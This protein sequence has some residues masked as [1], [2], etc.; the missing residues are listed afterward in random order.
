MRPRLLERPQRLVAVLV[1][2]TAVLLGLPVLSSGELRTVTGEGEYR[3]GARDTREDAVRLATEEAKRHALEQVATYIESVSVSTA[4]D[5]TKDEIRTY[6]AGVVHVIDQ[7]VSIRIEENAVIVRVDVTA[8]LDPDEVTQAIVALRQNEDAREQVRLLKTEV[9]D[10][11]RELADV[12]DKLAAAN[13]PEQLQLAT[14]QRQELLSRVESNDALGQAWTNWALVPW[15][16]PTPW[17]G[18]NVVQGLW[19]QAW[20]LYPA[21]PHLVVLQRVLP[22]QIPQP[23]RGAPPGVFSRAPRFR[24]GPLLAIPAPPGPG[25]SSRPLSTMHPP[26]HVPPAIGH[27]RSRVPMVGQRPHAYV[28]HGSAPRFSRGG[29]GRAHR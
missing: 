18:M 14:Q 19:A 25:F 28:P 9:D 22:V 2:V 11:H 15:G 5:L 17:I 7:D 8:L 23:P 26:L 29:H 16:S 1:I 3:M 10:L 21:N 13:S 12:S 27:L 4:V 20:G 6:T 24:P